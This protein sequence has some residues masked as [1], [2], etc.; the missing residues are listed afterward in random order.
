MDS[1]FLRIDRED[2]D[3]VLRRAIEIE[4]NDRMM[5]MQKIP[6]FKSWPQSEINEINP[7]SSIKHFKINTVLMGD[8]KPG[9]MSEYVYFVVKGRCHIVRRITMLETS[10]I[11][12]KYDSCKRITKFKR[13]PNGNIDKYLEWNAVTKNWRSTKLQQSEK[14][15]NMFDRH[16]IASTFIGKQISQHV[17]P[18]TLLKRQQSRQTVV[19]ERATRSRLPK[20]A[21]PSRNKLPPFKASLL[22]Q[23]VGDCISEE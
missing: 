12:G 21:T 9:D 19:S 23:N 7:H 1:E 4:W 18:N 10:K 13:I 2:F 15:S 14:S 20:K 11:I 17:L 5:E 6:Y 8:R 16:H 3:N 22:T